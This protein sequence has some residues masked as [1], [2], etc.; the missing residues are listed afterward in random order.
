MS[1]NPWINSASAKFNG[2]FISIKTYS[3]YRMAIAD[4]QASEYLLLPNDSNEILGKAAFKALTDS[5]FLTI[6]ESS[7]LREASEENYKKWIQKI[8]SV[9]G[10]KTK[11]TLFQKMINC[12]LEMDEG[13]ITIFPSH[14]EKLEAWSGKG[15][16]EKD[17][18]KVPAD[19]SPEEIGAAL[20]LAFS[21]CTG[22]RPDDHLLAG[23]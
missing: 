11:R 22:P 1:I 10:Y 16:T 18:V 12:S 4:P 6:E 15:L 17:Y 14:H 21:R 3:G 23:G 5:R 7:K 19:S 2:D 9:Y 13:I 20:R 8:M